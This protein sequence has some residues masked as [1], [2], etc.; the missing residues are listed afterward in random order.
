MRAPAELLDE[1]GD[2]SPNASTEPGCHFRLQTVFWNTLGPGS[3]AYTVTELLDNMCAFSIEP[4][5]WVL[6]ESRDYPRTY[7]RP[8]LP[9]LVFRALC[10]AGVSAPTQGRI[11]GRRVLNAIR[12]GDLLY[13]WPPYD[14][15]LMKRAKDR[16]AIVIA[17]RINCMAEM[18]RGVLKRAYGRRGLGLPEG[19]FDARHIENEREQ[20]LL[21]DFVMAPNEFVADSARFAGIS[22]E[23]I[24][25]TSYGFSPDRLA[26][27]IGIQRPPRRPVFTFVGLGIVR[28][29]ID[30]LLEAWEQ[31]NINGKLL[32]AGHMDE[33]M[34]RLYA[35]V[36]ERDDVQELGYV[37]DIARVYASADV[38]VFPSHEEGGPQV[39]Y[40]AAACKLPCIVS[41]MGAGRIVRD[42]VEGVVVDPCSV[43]ELAAAITQLAE[44]ELFRNRLAG[45][46]ETRARQFTWSKVAA[47]RF[48]QLCGVARSR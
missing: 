2:D 11:A 40:E 36:L 42:Q 24:L 17:E 46:A 34:R 38:F 26:S 15:N 27:A 19:W 41:P 25:H 12:P 4:S 47:H 23:R 32:I 30:V 35:R 48:R 16:G 20:M 8:A 31:A 21:C 33:E 3:V 18:A 6:G 13:M 7:H 10:K 45:N 39:T 14:A 28:K 9:K 37:G 5:L 44:D 22:E 43:D 29:G 1:L